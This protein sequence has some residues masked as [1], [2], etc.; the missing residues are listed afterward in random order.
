MKRLTSIPKRAIATMRFSQRTIVFSFVILAVPALSTTSYASPNT[1]TNWQGWYGGLALGGAYSAANPDGTVEHNGYMD[2]VDTA[3][4][5]PVLQRKIED[6]DVTGSALLGYD[7]QSGHITYGI[8]G[9]LTVMDYSESEGASGIE[10]DNNAGRFFTT[11]TTVETNFL[12]SLRPKVGYATGNFQFYVSAGPSIGRFKTTVNYSDTN[13]NG[14]N[15]N[16]TDTT[17]AFGVSSSIGAG[18]QI[19]DGWALRGDYVFNYYPDIL[20]GRSDVDNDGDTDINFGSD[21]QSHNVRFA[22][23]KHF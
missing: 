10:Y 1:T 19:G 20:D 16:F 8:E 13:V 6:L 3:Q 2:A 7:F 5:D 4:V 12:L 18:Y 11:K 17:M 14:A 21:F 22:L 9:D 15:E 23:I